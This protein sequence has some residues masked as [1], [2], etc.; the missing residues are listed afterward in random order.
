MADLIFLALLIAL[1]Y[2]GLQQRLLGDAGTGWHIRNGEHILQTHAIPRQ[3]YFSYTKTGQPW[4]AWEWLSDVLMGAIYRHLGLNG[5]VFFS[6]LLI[7]TTFAGL[8]RLALV[9]SKDLLSTITIFIPA[10][11]AS[12]IHFLARPHLFT[13]FLTLIWWA[14]L[15]YFTVN[16]VRDSMCGQFG[17][18]LGETRGELSESADLLLI[19][20]QIT[21]QKVAVSRRP[22]RDPQVWHPVREVIVSVCRLA[23]LEL[24]VERQ[25]TKPRPWRIAEYVHRRA[26]VRDEQPASLVILAKH[27]ADSVGPACKKLA[28][29][30]GLECLHRRAG[31]E[32]DNAVGERHA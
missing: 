11:M 15:E 31:L 10:L 5:V 21:L 30:P 19:Q 26:R 2:G 28:R 1:T 13:W 29:E 25:G 12:S 32:P 14:I 18:Q 23:A 9:R 17:A 6:A 8:L 22:R 16:R 20:R 24:G 27:L 4:F 3:D 7:A